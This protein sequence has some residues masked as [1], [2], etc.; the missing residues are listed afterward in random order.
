MEDMDDV[1]APAS[2]ERPTRWGPLHPAVG[3][4]AI[5][6][7]T[8]GARATPTP[9]ARRPLTPAASG[10]RATRWGPRHGAIGAAA[11]AHRVTGEPTVPAPAVRPPLPASPR[12]AMTRWG[13]RVVV[14]VLTTGR[15]TCLR[16][17]SSIADRAPAAAAAPV[18]TDPPPSP[19]PSPASPCPSIDVAAGAA[20]SEP[21]LRRFDGTCRQ[22]PG[23]G[24]RWCGSLRLERHRGVDLIALTPASTGTNNTAE[25]TTLLLGVQSAVHH[26]ATRL[27]VKGD[28]NLEL[29]QVRGSFGCTNRRLRRLRGQVRTTL[30]CLEWNQLRHID[31]QANAH[32]DRL[33]NRALDV[34]RTA[35]ECGPHSGDISSC[36]TPAP[37]PSVAPAP[38]L[39]AATAGDSAVA[40]VL[41]D[42]ASLAI[43]AEI[44]ARDGEHD[45]AAS[46]VQRFAEVLVSK[47]LDADSWVTS[48]GYISA[49]P[50]RLREVLL[51]YSIAPVGST[52][53][54]LPPTRPPR[55]RPPR[56]TRTQREHRFDEA[57]DDMQATQQA[58][59]SNR[60]AVRKARRRVGR[61]RASI[62]QLDLRRDFAK[63]EAKCVAMI[64]DGASAKTA[65]V[66]HPNTCPIDR[67]ELYRHFVGTSTAPAPFNYDAAEGHEFR[68]VLNGF[69]MDTLGGDCFDGDISMD[70]VEDQL[71]RAA[72]A[73]SPGHDGV[74][75]DVFRRFAPQLVPLLHAAYQFCWLHR[76]VTV[77]WKVGVV[78]LIHK[79]GDPMQPTN[80]RPMCLQPAIYKLYSGLLARRLSR[81]LELNNRLPMAQ[82]GFRAF[83]GCH[84]H[85]FLATT[86]LDQSRRSHRKL[87]QVWYDLRNAFGS[88]PQP[89][90]WQVLRRIGVEPRFINHCQDIY[91]ESSFVVVNSQDGATDPLEDVGVPLADG[92]RPCTTAYA[93]DI[94]VFSNSAAG[95][96]SFHVVV[97]RFLAWTGLAVTINAR[98]NP[99][100]DD[101]VRLEL[102][103]DVIVPLTLNESYRY[104]GVGDGFD[105]V[106]H[107]LQLE[108]KLKQIKR[109]TVALMQSG[110]AYALRHLRPLQSQLQGF[111][112]AVKR[113]W[114]HLL[115]LPQS[116]T[117]EFFYTPTSGGGLGLQSLLLHSKDS[118]IVAVAKTQVCQ[119]VRKRY[120]LIED[121]WVGR[122]DELIRLFL[123][124]E[125]ASSPHA[126]VIRRSGDIASLWVDV[127][128]VMCFHHLCLADRA[129][130]DVQGQFAL[131]VPHHDKWL[132]H[133]DVLRH[134]ARVHGGSGSKFV[135]SGAG[136]SDAE[137]WLG[138]QARL[139]QVDTNSVLK[140]RRLRANAHFRA[141]T[142]SSAETLAH[143][144]NHCTPNMVSIR[145][146]HDY[147]LEQKVA[148]IRHALVRRKSGA[149]LRI[150]QTVPEYTGAALHP[151]IVVRDV[152]AKIMVIA[153]LAVTFEDHAAS[154][155][156]SSLQLSHDFKVNKYQ[157]I[158]AELRLNRWRVQTT[159]LVYGSLG[160]VHPSNLKTYTE[161]LGLLKI[162]ARQLDLQ[163]LSHCVRS[164]HRIWSWHCRQ[165]GYRQRGGTA[166][167]A[168]HRSGGTRQSTS[169]VRAR[170]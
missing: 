51:P 45:S 102:N 132:D 4:A 100:R 84:E 29:A 94:K 64:L 77:P 99:A 22:N 107:R 80:W 42:P 49:I 159:A 35:V 166:S 61:V 97:K 34:R 145:Q 58:T 66:E 27:L 113:G 24:G 54:Q 116:A 91:H 33:A 154:A 142:C 90:M 138:I 89:L 36:F 105:H 40:V 124:L 28:S 86:M 15:L 170:R 153:D 23:P 121:H 141:P 133:K 5:T 125:L 21:W 156:H 62:A 76:M 39:P 8:T 127:Q 48:E 81:W 13:P 70:E 41:A 117:T 115:R 2:T 96:Q 69:S 85:N 7:P 147:A 122:N 114:R 134:T 3:A 98:G 43:E 60:Q 167:R 161:T 109:E 162:E 139:N 18:P 135:L 108:P 20:E 37:V 165:H 93:D 1:V 44:A 67:E 12:H 73:S 55:R 71:L 30:G 72:K 150:N 74:G 26:G 9:A 52:D 56:V 75:Y 31:R 11:V 164:S 6:P 87:Y 83:N 88:L 152:A 19:A 68:A 10:T 14:T 63:D 110:L 101:S 130:D 131:R 17:T 169:Q 38:I 120:R 168:L 140:R 25:Y 104:L 16:R 47:T 46:V 128:R 53:P 143:V 146:R 57:L 136:L 129:E 160:S 111:D 82:K 148:K 59:T 32:A 118:A 155:R 106:Q 50:D 126:T 95:I 123:N 149:E 78:R 151:Y 79:K 112:C 144:L 163:L 92:V 119:V 158:V 103:G 157:P 137:H 65:G